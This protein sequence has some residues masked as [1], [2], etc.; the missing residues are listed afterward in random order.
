MGLLDRYLLRV[1]RPSAN[2]FAAVHENLREIERH[3]NAL[4]VP[5]PT[6]IPF[7]GGNVAGN[8]TAIVKESFTFA[9][10]R[11]N[12]VI[13]VNMFVDAAVGAAGFGTVFFYAYLDGVAIDT[14]DYAALNQ[15]AIRAG[16]G[17]AY[18]TT[19][20]VPGNHTLELWAKTTIAAGTANYDQG[21]FLLWVL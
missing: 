12:T 13:A 2:T 10:A 16:I 11:P 8:L 17:T 18:V 5:A 9:T 19:I 20:P 21:R 4:P 1:K 14:T 6:I 15:A 7:A 3:T